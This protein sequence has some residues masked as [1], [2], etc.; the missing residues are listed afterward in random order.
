MIHKTKTF[1]RMTSRNHVARRVYIGLH[2]L[3]WEE[4][5]TDIKAQGKL[6]D[7]KIHCSCPLCSCKSTK[8][9]NKKT[10]SLAGYSAS[11]KRKFEALNY[12]YAEFIGA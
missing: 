6:R 10:N 2:C 11:D 4:L 12:S 5:S 3:S 9:L 1:R 7:G 8:Y